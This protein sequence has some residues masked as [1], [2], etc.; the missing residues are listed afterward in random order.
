MQAKM[1]RDIISAPRLS[2]IARLPNVIVFALQHFA[3][4]IPPARIPIEH[5]H[6]SQKRLRAT[7]TRRA[8]RGMRL[9]RTMSPR[10]LRAYEKRNKKSL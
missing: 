7:W 4:D 8:G 3:E 5:Q 1:K 9:L 2:I 6:P 10:I